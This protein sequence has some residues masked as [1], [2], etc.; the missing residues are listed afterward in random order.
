[1][2]R[3][4]CLHILADYEGLGGTGEA[5]TFQNGVLAGCTVDFDLLKS[6]EAGSPV[7]PKSIQLEQINPDYN[8]PKHHYSA[9]FPFQFDRKI[10]FFNLLRKLVK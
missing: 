8:L 10:S 4:C 7:L 3:P 6:W 1:M 5:P 9:D 2:P